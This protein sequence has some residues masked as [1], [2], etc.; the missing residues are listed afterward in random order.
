[1]TILQTLPETMTAQQVFDHVCEHLMQQGERS[2]DGD[3]CRYRGPNGTAC[4][5]GCL[6]PN[7]FYRKEMEGAD[8]KDIKLPPQLTPH[9]ELL[10]DLQRVHDADPINAWPAGLRKVANDF[11]LTIPSCIAEVSS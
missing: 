11:N 10:E 8:V 2:V 7:H 6:I 3:Y 1:M 4:A 5:V 9:E